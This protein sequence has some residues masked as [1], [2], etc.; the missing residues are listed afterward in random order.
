[1]RKIIHP[2]I[3]DRHRRIFKEERNVSVGFLALGEKS[4]KKVEANAKIIDQYSRSVRFIRSSAF[5]MPLS[6]K[7]FG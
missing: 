3:F 4:E 5:S 7:S 6:L 1:M 2:Y